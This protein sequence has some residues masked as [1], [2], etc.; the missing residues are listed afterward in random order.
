MKLSSEQI[1]VYNQRRKIPPTE[2]LYIVV[3]MIS[4]QNYG[5]NNSYSPSLP[6]EYN[7]QTSQMMQE[8]LSINLFS[9]DNQAIERLPEALGA[10]ASIYSEQVQEKYS[11]QIGRVPTAINDTSYLE[12]SAILFRQTITLRVLRAYSQITTADFYDN[13]TTEIYNETGKVDEYVND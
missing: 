1:W 12:A 3:G 5:N 7:Q 6:T 2:G 10:L 4:T 11:M 8:T 13:Y 9:Y